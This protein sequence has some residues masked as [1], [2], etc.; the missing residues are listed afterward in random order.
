MAKHNDYDAIVIGA[1][2][3]GLAAAI[4]LAREGLSVLVVEARDTI[5]GGTRT[6][7]LTLPGFAHDVCSAVHPLGAASP[8]FRTLPLEEHGLEWIHPAIPLAHPLDDGTAA[9]LERSVETTGQKLGPDAAAYQKLMAPL[10]AGWDRLAE[11]MLGPLSIPP[12]HPFILARFGL[13]A[14]RSARGLADST[15]QGEHARALF[16]GMAGHSMLPL[17]RSPTAAFG[18]LLGI[19]GH[20]VGWPLPRGG[21]QRISDA[22]ADYLRSLGA[23]IVTGTPVESIDELPPARLVLCDVAPQGLLRMAGHRLPARYRRK[24]EGYRYG[25]GVFKLDLALDGPIPWQAEA[26]IRAGT[27]HVG[28]T[29]SEIA[30]AERAVWSGQHPEKP[31]VLLAQ[32]SLFDPTRSPAGKHTVWAYCHVPHASTVDMTGRIEAQIE[33]FAPGF[34]DRILARSVMSASEMEVYNPN[35]IGGD[36][37]GGVQDLRQH[38]TRPTFRL[39]PYSTPVKGLYLCSSSTPPGGGVHGMCGYF[40]ARAALRNV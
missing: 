35:Y 34:R 36:I 24:L 1:G 14:I 3:N 25:P 23:E 29:L 19:T 27:V 15:F 12:R 28:G 31:F 2:P 33:R 9:V 11:D 21:S 6:A 32:Q 10:V 38:F 13:R 8:F 39:V 7:E 17:E 16:A 18:L 26:C 30:A 37:N 20:A 5:G 22:M 40:A 4:S